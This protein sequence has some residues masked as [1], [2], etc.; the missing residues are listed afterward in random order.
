MP[1]GSTLVLKGANLSRSTE[2]YGAELSTKP[3]RQRFFSSANQLNTSA[4][5]PD[6]SASR[7]NSSAR[8]L[9]TSANE[10]HTSA[11]HLHASANQFNTSAD[12][13]HTSASRLNTSAG[14]LDKPVSR[15]NEPAKNL[16]P[17]LIYFIFSLRALNSRQMRN[18]KSTVKGGLSKISQKRIWKRYR[19]GL[20]IILSGAN[21]R[22]LLV[23]V[24]SNFASATGSGIN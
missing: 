24:T 6:T 7:L 18:N 4:N 3:C 14:N 20:E 21:A 19:K 17:F 13:L 15:L 22:L 23:C 16:S 9:N 8:H 12:A 5:R 11:N 1:V 2:I 10:I